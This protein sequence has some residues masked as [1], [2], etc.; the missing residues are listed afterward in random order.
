MGGQCWEGEAKGAR[1][2][3]GRGVVWFLAEGAKWTGQVG[4]AWQLLKVGES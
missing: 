2:T 4:A 1:G 3:G